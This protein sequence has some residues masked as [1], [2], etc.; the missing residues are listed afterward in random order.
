MEIRKWTKRT[1]HLIPKKIT[2][3]GHL[4]EWEEPYGRD[5]EIET[6]IIVQLTGLD[7]EPP[8]NGKLI[9]TDDDKHLYYVIEHTIRAK[10]LVKSFILYFSGEQYGKR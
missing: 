3:D 7:E 6:D 5:P 1:G 9:P 8:K 10:G 2:G 4:M